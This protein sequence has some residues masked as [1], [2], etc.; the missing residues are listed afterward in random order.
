[1]P[2]ARASAPASSATARWWRASRGARSA[3]RLLMRSGDS[4]ARACAARRRRTR[5]AVRAPGTARR[6]RAGELA[7]GIATGDRT[8]RAN[9]DRWGVY[10]LT[11]IYA[12]GY[13]D[14]HGG[15]HLRRP[16]RAR[17]AT[18][19]RP[20]ARALASRGRARRGARPE[21]ARRVQAP[22]RAARR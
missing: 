4:V 3:S 7:S 18:D 10:V 20:P 13:V 6:R 22:A 21:P 2:M 17:A 11:A 8:K 12:D 19:P 5:R 15:D 9:L 1:M 14:V 16:R